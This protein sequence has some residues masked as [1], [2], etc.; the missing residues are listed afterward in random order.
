MFEL[1]DGAFNVVMEHRSNVN[2]S[3]ISASQWKIFH[4]SQYPSGSQVTDHDTALL[5]LN[6]CKFSMAQQSHSSGFSPFGCDMYSGTDQ[7]ICAMADEII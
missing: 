7:C 6:S 1:S 5:P 2:Q 3:L 4:L